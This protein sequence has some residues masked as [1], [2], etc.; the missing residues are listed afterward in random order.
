MSLGYDWCASKPSEVGWL[1][2]FR[3]VRAITKRFRVKWP[4]SWIAREFEGKEKKPGEILFRLEKGQKVIVTKVFLDDHPEMIALKKRVKKRFDGDD[5]IKRCLE[6]DRFDVTTPK[7]VSVMKGV[8]WGFVDMFIDSRSRQSVLFQP[9]PIP[10]LKRGDIRKLVYRSL[11]EENEQEER[12]ISK[13][14]Y[15][16]VRKIMTKHNRLELLVPY[17]FNK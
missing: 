2:T 15:Q 4:H 3:N 16:A 11:P 13:E 8:T 17:S 14:I 10:I 12:K 1:R 5:L 6:R 7:G 9:V